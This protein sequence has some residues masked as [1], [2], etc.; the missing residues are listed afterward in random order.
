MS[1]FGFVY[2]LFQTRFYEVVIVLVCSLLECRSY[3]SIYTLS[4]SIYI[5]TDDTCLY[6]KIC[7]VRYM[8]ASM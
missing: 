8:D 5:C 6:I 2:P 3:V 4:L 1:S 7:K